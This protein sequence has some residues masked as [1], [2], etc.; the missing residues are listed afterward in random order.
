MIGIRLF[1]MAIDTGYLIGIVFF[2]T[3]FFIFF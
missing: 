3:I 1:F 2:L